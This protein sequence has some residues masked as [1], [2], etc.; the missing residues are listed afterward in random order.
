MP[1]S[2]KSAQPTPTTSPTIN[3]VDDDDFSSSVDGSTK[4][5][6]ESSLVVIDVVFSVESVTIDA[7]DAIVVV[8]DALDADVVDDTVVAL[9]PLVVDATFIIVVSRMQS[10]P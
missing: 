7:V 4:K 10:V 3:P 5:D 6:I 9:L 8:V 2:S 1:A